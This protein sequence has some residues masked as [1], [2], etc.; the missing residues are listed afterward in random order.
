LNILNNLFRLSFLS[1]L[2]LAGCGSNDNTPQL[3]MQ[4]DGAG[5]AGVGFT[6]PD[7]IRSSEAFDINA[8]GVTVETNAGTFNLER[9]DADGFIGSIDVEQGL[10]LTFTV[11]VWQEV[12]G[13]RVDF[14]TASGSANETIQVDTQIIVD[15]ENFT[16]PDDDGDLANNLEEIEAGSDPANSFSTPA[17]PDGA[18]PVDS[19]PGLVQ[20]TSSTFSV[21]E[22]D[23]SLSI[24][25]ARTGGSDGTATV[26]YELLDETAFAGSDFQAASG[27]LVWQDGDSS[28]QSF[29]VTI[30]SDDDIEG[31][32]TFS[33]RL[34]Q[35]T[36]GIAIGNGR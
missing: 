31:N 17:N 5:S 2:F 9:N 10:D 16:F 14:A 32:Q 20:F 25:V 34:F 3:Q 13:E 36:G 30:N 1:C 6:L 21:S 28:T 26:N 27:Q 24:S 33:A 22:A 18:A 4:A 15:F 23:G 8:V 35:P 19:N 7:R 12:S 29:T 11:T